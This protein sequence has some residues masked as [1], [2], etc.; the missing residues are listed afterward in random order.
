MFILGGG[1]KSG[2]IG[3]QPSL[4]KEHLQMGDL[5]FTTDFRSVYAS[6]LSNWLNADS[7]AILGRGFKSLDVIKT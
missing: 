4:A 5:K 7:G 2:L 1:I 6:I 3:T